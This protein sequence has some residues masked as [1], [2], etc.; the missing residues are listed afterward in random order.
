MQEKPL[1]SVVMI[2]Y[3][4][5][6]YIQEAI[7]GVFLQ[8]TDFL[9][10]LIIAND[11]SPDNSDEIIRETIKKAPENI[12]V[13]YTNHEKNKGMYVNSI[14]TL[15]QANGVYIAACEGDDYWTDENK[16]QQQVDFLEKNKD[17]AISYHRVQYLK[18]T[19]LAMLDHHRLKNEEKISTLEELS[20]TNF[21]NTLSAVF[22]KND[23]EIPDW[24]TYTSVGDYLLWL[25]ICRKGKIH[26]SPKTMGVY[27]YGTGFHSSQDAIATLSET[28]FSL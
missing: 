10:E 22:R 2:T 13:K 27:R 3:G 6:K 14:W 8:K 7:E 28:N 16:L 21:I 25:M 15:H 11:S 1:L 17:F 18:G 9:V 20:N 24:F 4:H 26:Y 5:E 23:L 12:I 19:E